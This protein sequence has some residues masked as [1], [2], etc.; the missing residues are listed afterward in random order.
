MVDY[1]PM[2]TL[3]AS[4]G[5]TH[6][7]LFAQAQLGLGNT[8]GLYTTTPKGRVKRFPP[9]YQYHFVPGPVQ[10]MRGAFKNKLNIP[11]WAYDWDSNA[12]D[13]MCSVVVEK[14]DMILGAASSSLYTGRV[15]K[16][17]GAKF[18]LD[19]AC[20]DIRVQERVVGEEAKK[21]KG[22]FTPAP[23][24]FL[25]RQI[26]EYEEADFIVSPSEY[27]RRS[28]PPHLKAKNILVRLTGNVKTV[29]EVKTHPPRPFTVGVV[30]GQPLR[31]GYLYLLEAW[32]Q[33]GWSD[34]RLLLRTSAPVIKE[35]A[36][37]ADLINNQPNVTMV[38]FVPDIADFF[39]QCD[40]FILPSIDD[41]FGLALFE[42]VG[43]GIPCIAT[44]NSG[45]SELLK[46]GEELMVI[47][48]FSAKAIAD[49]LTTL[50]ESPDLRQK[51]AVNGLNAVKA[52]Q[53]DF[54]KSQYKLG[55]DELMRRAFPST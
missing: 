38:N 46:A 39:Q 29:S 52:L 32:K 33:L 8:V 43:Q 47:E 19:R 44:S 10:L 9:G 41:G 4:E 7:E 2:H 53:V 22:P 42:A 3:I 30:G 25:Q 48:P 12:F 34:A 45:A 20:P 49:S 31:K 50:R 14:S 24:W 21:T 28:F 36:V 6:L 37:L 35:Y 13:R 40:V 1:S 11:R 5:L 17:K 23:D 26:A 16:K 15:A 54:S 51:L 55:I 18:V 27:S